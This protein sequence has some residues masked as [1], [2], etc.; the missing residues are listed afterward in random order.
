MLN[1]KETEY[2]ILFSTSRGE[3]K[4]INMAQLLAEIDHQH[5]FDTVD[6]QLRQVGMH[7]QSSLLHH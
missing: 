6:R 3:A 7:L 2:I 1:F 5:N 4:R